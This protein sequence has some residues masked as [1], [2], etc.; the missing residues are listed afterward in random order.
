MSEGL[1]RLEVERI[2][3]DDEGAA[4]QLI[5]RGR[6]VQLVN[7]AAVRIRV[8]GEDGSVIE[9]VLTRDDFLTLL[10]PLR[11]ILTDG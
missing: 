10:Q 6:E 2:A 3:P 1:E 4:A 8:E 11:G 7:A 9:D 5:R